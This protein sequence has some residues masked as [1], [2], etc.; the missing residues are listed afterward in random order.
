MLGAPAG[1]RLSLALEVGVGRTHDGLPEI[2]E[3]MRRVVR[4]LLRQVRARVALLV[5]VHDVRQTM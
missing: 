3:A 4:D 1:T 5:V 2:V